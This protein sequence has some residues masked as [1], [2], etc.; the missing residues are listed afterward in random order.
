M[1]GTKQCNLKGQ[2]DGAFTSI[3]LITV[4]AALLVLG[5]I[6]WP[7]M[8]NTKGKGQSTSCL[9]NHRQ[10]VRAWQ[11]YALR[12]HSVRKVIVWRTD[13]SSLEGIVGV[14]VNRIGKRAP[15]FDRLFSTP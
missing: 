6:Q 11:S 5:A 13:Q 8:A 15:N 9:S 14:R 2:S 12:D 7:S 3:D 10:F 1:F 4:V